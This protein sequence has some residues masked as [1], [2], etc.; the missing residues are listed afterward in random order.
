MKFVIFDKCYKR[1]Y[2]KTTELRFFILLL[3]VQHFTKNENPGLD[4][5]KQIHHSLN[6]EIFNLYK[7]IKI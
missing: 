1:S 4:K 7:H 3:V 5:S 6:S 2:Y